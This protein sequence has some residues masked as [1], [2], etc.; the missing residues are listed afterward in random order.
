MCSMVFFTES[1]NTSKGSLS[2]KVVGMR[3]R[4]PLFGLILCAYSN[5]NTKYRCIYDTL[6]QGSRNYVTGFIQHFKNVLETF[7]T[8]IIRVW[9]IVI[10]VGIG[11][12]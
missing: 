6:F 11:F 9:D 10:L 12:V 5:K 4:F 7:S 2:P 3:Y 8:A 1:G